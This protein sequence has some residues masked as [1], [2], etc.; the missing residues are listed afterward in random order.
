MVTDVVNWDRGA[1]MECDTYSNAKSSDESFTLIAALRLYFLQ[2]YVASGFRSVGAGVN[3]NNHDSSMPLLDGYVHP[4]LELVRTEN[5]DAVSAVNDDRPRVQSGTCSN[6]SQRKT[7]K[8]TEG[9]QGQWTDAELQLAMDA[10]ESGAF[11]GAASRFYGIPKTS[12]SD[13]VNGRC[14]GRK[15]GPQ[16][17][18]N[19]EEVDALETYMR[20]MAEYGHPLTT[21]QLKLKVAL[22]TQERPTPFTNGV[23][24]NSW[25]M[26]FRN[27][28]PNLTVSQSQSLEFARAKGL[29]KL[30][31]NEREHITTLTYINAVG[32]HIPNFYIFKGK[33]IREKYIVHCED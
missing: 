22:L 29:N 26:W 8:K 3:V 33:R 32:Q 20:E 28:H 9:P 4:V 1:G 19:Q 18:L 14:R 23:L 12:L 24:G 7:S 13:H 10:V 11:I 31:P 15:R 17:V 5:A 2:S 25:L 30:T 21:E 27:R 16:P 6:R